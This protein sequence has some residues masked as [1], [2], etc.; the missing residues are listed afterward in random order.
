MRPP[1]A[2]WTTDS[3]R[4]RSRGIPGW[5]DLTLGQTPE[6]FGSMPFPV[7]YHLLSDLLSSNFSAVRIK[8]AILLNPTRISAALASAIRQK[9]QTDGKTVLYSA[10]VAVLD[11]S[12][13]RTEDGGQKLT[14]L[15]GL[16]QGTSGIKNRMTTF[17][18]PGL[19]W[20]SASAQAVWQPLVGKEVGASWPATP[21]YYYNMS[22]AGPDEMATVLGHFEGTS[23]PSLVQVKLANHTAVFSS[24]PIATGV[25]TEAYLALALAAGV[26]SYT[27]VSSST[28]VEAGGNMLVVHHALKP[29]A[30]AAPLTCTVSLPRALIVHATNG[31]VVCT[32]C[33]EFEDCA[34]ATRTQ[35][36][37]VEEA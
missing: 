33:T 11:G 27:A 3:S 1:G 12:G 31:R 13:R 4:E 16:V 34:I 22:A 15:T 5:P 9:L 21:W 20:A 24:N 14:G 17:A 19:N 23:L 37:L 26:H 30:A 32:N 2:P 6:I 29:S 10:A 28:R 35:V 25:S 8:L 7:R 36:Y 18:A